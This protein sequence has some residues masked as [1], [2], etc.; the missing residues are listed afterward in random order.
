[1]TDSPARV[2]LFNDIASFVHDQLQ[3]TNPEPAAKRRRVDDG[4]VANGS[5]GGDTNGDA[6]AEE[7]LLEVKE[8]S[9]SVPQRKKFELCFT[10]KHLYARAPGTSGPVAGIVYAWKDIGRPAPSNKVPAA[11]GLR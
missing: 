8:I 6:S 3:T 9:V 1:M 4:A 10:A 2:A 5:A 7:V 11:S